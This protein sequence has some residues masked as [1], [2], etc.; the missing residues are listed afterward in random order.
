MLLHDGHDAARRDA[1]VLP[2]IKPHRA[3]EPG[4]EAAIEIH[5]DLSE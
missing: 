3:A 5:R 2:H 1:A 4:T